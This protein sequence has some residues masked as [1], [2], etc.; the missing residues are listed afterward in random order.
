MPVKRKKIWTWVTGCIIILALIL[1]IGNIIA[2]SI[3]RKKFDTALTQF[4]TYIMAEYKDLHIN[5]LTG[6][7]SVDSFTIQYKP[8][9]SH[10]QYQHT[11]YLETVSI[12]GITYFKMRSVKNYT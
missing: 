4:Q 2:K 6:S 9:T 11:T 8:D 10:P 12:T 7:F 3:I 5:L 1:I